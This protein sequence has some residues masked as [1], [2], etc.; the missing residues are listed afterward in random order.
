MKN[1]EKKYIFAKDDIT[2]STIKS[3]T[4]ATNEQL[5]KSIL[6]FQPFLARI[7]QR[8]KVINNPQ[9]I[10]TIEPTIKELKSSAELY[11][12]NLAFTYLYGIFYQRKKINPQIK[13]KL[14]EQEISLTDYL[15]MPLKFAF[16]NNPDI[17]MPFEEALD[18]FGDSIPM[19]RQQV[20]EL[21]TSE[22][23]RAFWL[24]RKNYWEALNGTHRALT[25]ALEQGI[26]FNEWLET[27]QDFF[28]RL[29]FN[30]A[31]PYYLEN[32]YRTNIMSSFNAG[33]FRLL[34]QPLVR[35]VLEY[36]RY[37][38][39]N[40]SRT[41]PQDAAMDGTIALNDDP[42]WDVW[43]PPNHYQCRC[44]VIAISRN[45]AERMGLDTPDSYIQTPTYTD[46][47]GNTITATPL[48]GFETNTGRDWL[49]TNP[50]DGTVPTGFA[51]L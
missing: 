22:R 16:P 24:T 51:N 43:Y 50:N 7:M 47:D 29:G 26:G 40:D 48:E 12:D 21:A 15:R 19:T 11:F 2:I 34:D 37:R 5:K 44:T 39:V 9:D 33:Q 3:V 31:N 38:S 13:E 1:F 42:I 14:K 35:G 8:I 23:A 30:V 49:S 4:N 45:M 32:V 6:Q 36:W 27:N 20:D 46:K 41:A 25:E 18:Y 28:Q 17:V 10:F